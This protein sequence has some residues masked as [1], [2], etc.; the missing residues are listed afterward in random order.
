MRGITTNGRD[1]MH[2]VSTIG[3]IASFVNIIPIV[4]ITGLI[5]EWFG[6]A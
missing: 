6:G 1:A 2:Y 5:N 4:F 3:A